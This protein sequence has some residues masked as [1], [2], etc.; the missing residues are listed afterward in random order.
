MNEMQ[1]KIQVLS[2]DQFQLFVIFRTCCAC[3]STNLIFPF[4]YAM[5]I[6]IRLMAK[7]SRSN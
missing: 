2:F 5:Q 6:D 3:G 4:W 1:I 7:Y